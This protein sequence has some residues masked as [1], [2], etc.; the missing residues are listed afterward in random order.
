MSDTTAKS[1]RPESSLSARISNL[2]VAQLHTYTGRGPTKAWTSIDDDLVTVVVR[3]ALTKGERS[4]VANS[5]SELVLEMRHAYQKTMGPDLVRGIEEL[6][7]RKVQAFMSANHLDPD[8]AIESF[9]LEPLNGPA[10]GDA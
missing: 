10:D 8:I 1:S 6:T 2:V 4:L 3:D 5:R 7:G 9:V